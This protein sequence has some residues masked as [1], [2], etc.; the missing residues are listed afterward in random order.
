[1]RL[2]TYKVPGTDAI[3]VLFTN[4]AG[5][6]SDLIK[7]FP[8]LLGCEF[9]LDLQ[10]DI[11]QEQVSEDRCYLPF[12]LINT[13]IHAS[14]VV[15]ELEQIGELLISNKESE[16]RVHDML[17]ET[18]TKIQANLAKVNNANSIVETIPLPL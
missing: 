16:Q 12:E 14:T 3:G 11:Q 13:S 9:Q 7:M 8:Y 10:V 4:N 6:K 18:E 1:M 17:I 2:I 15:T 5:L